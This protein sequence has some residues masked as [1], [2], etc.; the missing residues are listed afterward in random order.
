MRLNLRRGG[1]E[2]WW[3]LDVDLYTTGD[4]I[5]LDREESDV[6]DELLG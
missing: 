6:S 5:Y 4:G 2:G 1:G 3:M